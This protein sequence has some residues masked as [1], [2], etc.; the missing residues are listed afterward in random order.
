MSE[1]KPDPYFVGIKFK[2][3]EKSYFFSTD[4]SDL[5]C[6]DLVVVE[7]PNGYEM[8]TL[9][10]NLISQELYH[11]PLELKP[12][13]RKPTKDNMDDYAFNLEQDRRALEITQREVDKLGLPMNL[14]DADYNLDG[15]KITI[16]YTSPEHRVD[17]RELLK[18][19][20]PVL[21][22]RIEFHQLSPRERARKIGGIGICGLPFCCSTFLVWAQSVGIALAKN[23]MLTLNTSKLSGPC[24]KLICCL[25]YENE[26]YDAEKRDFPHLGTI[27]HLEEG[28]Y[29]VDSFNIVSRTVRLANA[30]RDNFKTYSLDDV[31]AM[32]DGTYKKKEEKPKED[33]LPDFDI[34]NL[35]TL[36]RDEEKRNDQRNNDRQRQKQ[37]GK[38]NNQN[39]G[40]QNRNN[41]NRNNN[42]NNGNNRPQNGGRPQGN[43]GNNNNSTHHYHSHHGGYHSSR[44]G[45]QGNKQQ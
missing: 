10:T 17:F 35:Q 37:H 25:A 11:S 24:G 45:G 39:R 14:L 34:P 26:T 1:I 16:T 36:K 3:S 41:Q 20:P 22:A 2:N 23:Q 31:K 29:H 32:M 19:L 27:V 40:N 7:T 5:K 43:G 18:I 30:K 15:S 9:S 42:Q 44:R 38:G 12:I 33:E 8:A 6:G 13:L 4:M 21:H 28:E